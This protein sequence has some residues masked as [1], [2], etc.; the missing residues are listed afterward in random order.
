[1]KKKRK[2]PKLTGVSTP[3]G[4]VSWAPAE[5]ERKKRI[6]S[7]VE[8]Y[9]AN[10]NSHPPKTS[11]FNGLVQAGVFILADDSEIREVCE[12]VQEYGDRSPLG[13]Y[14]DKLQDVDLHALFAVAKKR[15][16]DFLREG[17]P[18]KIANE[19]K[20][21]EDGQTSLAQQPPPR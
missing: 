18:E 10:A 9:R 6:E 7:V 4:G 13:K 17:N 5:D 3:F 11:G 8:T 16:Y 12:R 1:M 19:L 14:E 21:R 20:A 2:L 15:G